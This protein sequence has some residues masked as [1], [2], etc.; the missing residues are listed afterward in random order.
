[1]STSLPPNFPGQQP[2]DELSRREKKYH[3]IIEEQIAEAQ[4]RGDFDNLR[5]KGKPLDL[6]GNP[7]ARDWEMAY[8]AMSNAGYAPDWIERDK[9]IRVMIDEVRAMLE[10]HV[11]WHNEAVAA[12]ETLAEKARS[13]RRQVIAN[14]RVSVVQ[15]YQTRVA[16]INTKIGNYN[17]I[18]PVPHMQRFKLRPDEDIREFEARLS[19]L[20]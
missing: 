13:Q 8:T 3:D 12:L 17:L 9:E 2:P 10:R 18:C 5:G 11:A 19:P 6:R 1:M 4:Q 7:H 14:A 16:Q 15:R 20:P